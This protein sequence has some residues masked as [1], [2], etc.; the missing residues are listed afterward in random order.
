MKRCGTLVYTPV[1][2]RWTFESKT[3]ERD[4]HCGDVFELH[5]DGR[6]VP[7]RLEL[8]DGGWYVIIRER[9]TDHRIRFLLMKNSRYHVRL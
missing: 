2:D 6:Y 5:I 7:C 8:Y 4:M 1:Y 9:R 3:L